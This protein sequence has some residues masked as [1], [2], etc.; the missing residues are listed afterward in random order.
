MKNEI[1]KNKVKVFISSRECGTDKKGNKRYERYKFVRRAIKEMLEETNMAEVYVREL[2]EASSS[3]L[4]ETYIQEINAHHICIFIVDNHDDK[5]EHSQGVINEYEEAKRLNKKCLYFFCDENE[6]SKTNIEKEV[7]T[8]SNPM[9]KHVHVFDDIPFSVYKGVINDIIR[10]YREKCIP[11]TQG[12]SEDVFMTTLHSKPITQEKY[13]E[14]I[15]K[16]TPHILANSNTGYSTYKH[17]FDNFILLKNEF[18]KIFGLSDTVTK[19]NNFDEVCSQL[20]QRTICIT[21]A[22]DSLYSSMESEIRI[23]HPPII[24]EILVHRITAIQCYFTGDLHGCMNA[25]EK[26]VSG[27]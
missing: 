1:I 7:R 23:L 18:S 27:Q 6:K 8:P 19:N 22:E 10:I 4:I 16:N 17:K 12:S 13:L 24:H 14:Y 5:D 26:A 2:E 3:P 9:Y 25:L 21:N 20:F 11:I 15:P